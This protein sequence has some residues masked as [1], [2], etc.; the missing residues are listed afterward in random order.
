[1]PE[2]GHASF[3]VKNIY[4]TCIHLLTYLLILPHLRLIDHPPISAWSTTHP[5]TPAHT[6][7]PPALTMK[8]QAAFP[9]SPFG[10]LQ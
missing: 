9:M 1:M 2:P 5:P 4:N 7:M 3:C 8:S 6:L 10:W